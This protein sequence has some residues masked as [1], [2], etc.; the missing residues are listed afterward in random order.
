MR[1]SSC[2]GTTT[3]QVARCLRTASSTG[4]TRA[5]AD[6]KVDGLIVVCSVGTLRNACPQVVGVAGDGID[7]TGVSTTFHNDDAEFKPMANAYDEALLNRTAAVLGVVH[8]AAAKDLIVTTGSP[9]AL[10]SKPRPKLTPSNG[11]VAGVGMTMPREAKLAA[12]FGLPYVALCIAANWAAGRSPEGRRTDLVH[13]EA[14]LRRTGVWVRCGPCFSI[15]SKLHLLPIGRHRAWRRMD[16]SVD[17]WMASDD[18]A[19]SLMMRA[20]LPSIDSM[21]SPGTTVTTWGTALP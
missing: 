4:P 6:A 12:E 7:L 17:G 9:K 8:G 5:M 15:R 11:L 19:W 16:M 10:S 20:S 1:W 21:T 13:E 18:D 2:N 14:R 3:P